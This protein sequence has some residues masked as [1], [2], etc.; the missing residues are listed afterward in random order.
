MA[1]RLYTA[2]SMTHSVY[3]LLTYATYQNMLMHA[4][5]YTHTRMTCSVIFM[6][7]AVAVPQADCLVFAETMLL[8]RLSLVL[9]ACCKPHH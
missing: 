1:M 5:K 8:H 6:S 7:F 4:N 2:M 9:S 3:I